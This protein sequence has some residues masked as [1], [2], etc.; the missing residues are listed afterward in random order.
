MKKKIV[1]FFM[2][3]CMGASICACGSAKE[4]T[5]EEK[6]QTSEDKEDD[7]AEE[8][9]NNAVQESE[10]RF[11]VNKMIYEDNLITLSCKEITPESIVFEATNKTDYVIEWLQL[12]VSLDGVQLPL[13][14]YD[15]SDQNIGAQETRVITMGDYI[16]VAE[17]QRLS[18]SG[19]IFVNGSSKGEI[20][21]CDFELGG[22]ENIV[23]FETGSQVY[24]DEHVTVYFNGIAIDSMVFC[25]ENKADYAVTVG[26]WG[27]NRVV[28]NGKEYSSSVAVVNAHSKAVYAG[29]LGSLDGSPVQITELES[30]KGVFGV[31]G[32]QNKD[33]VNINLDLSK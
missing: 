33:I 16:G 7:T 26:F 30:L 15:S 13:F 23:S 2:C 5:I 4:T 29:Y 18:L 10:K 19:D 3:M 12:D 32:P 17:H 22:K 24:D 20:D 9:Q 27:D 21:I 6:K 11:E 1:L 14:S 25:V 8:V 28:I 31:K